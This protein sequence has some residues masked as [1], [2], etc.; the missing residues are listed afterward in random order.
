MKSIISLFSAEGQDNLSS[1]F[2]NMNN[3]WWAGVMLWLAVPLLPSLSSEMVTCPLAAPSISY[4]LLAATISFEN[5][6]YPLMLT[7]PWDN[8]CHCHQQGSD[9]AHI[10]CIHCFWWETFYSCLDVQLFANIVDILWHCTGTGELNGDSVRN[11]SIQVAAWRHA[12][13]AAVHP[14]EAPS[15]HAS[16]KCA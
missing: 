15:T 8:L 2:D 12:P 3:P 16:F 14:H 9:F 11:G 1:S 6:E 5:L 10:N 4:K 13:C 7:M